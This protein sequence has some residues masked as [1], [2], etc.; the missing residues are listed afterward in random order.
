MKIAFRHVPFTP[1]QVS[2]LNHLIASAGHEAVWCPNHE[3]PELAAIQDCEVLM[4]YFPADMFKDLPHL[5]WVQ[6]PSAGVEKLCGDIYASKDVVLTNCSGAFGV[7]ISEYMITGILMLMRRMPAYLSNQRAHIWKAMGSCRS[8]YGSTVTVIG[9][10]DIGTKFA[11]RMKG[12][13]ATVRGVRRRDC[14]RPDCFDAVYTSDRICEAVS[15]ADVVA[16]CVPGTREAQKLVSG[17]CIASMRPDTI[18]VNCGRGSTLDEEALIR[19]LQEK[20]LG[21]AVLDVATIEPLP[22]DSPLWDMENVIIT[23]HISGHDDDP[24]NYTSIFEIFKENLE[25]YLKHEPLKH[26]VNRERGY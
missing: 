9:M 22:A 10:G 3:R 6:T 2:V 14:A 24:V 25:H 7:A 16:M 1:E 5:K 4:G 8:I 26:V 12:L 15:G 11:T 21:G 19:A 23:P 13:G 17:A 18:L 20:K